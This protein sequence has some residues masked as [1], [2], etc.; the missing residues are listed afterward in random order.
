[1]SKSELEERER[2]QQAETP[3]LAPERRAADS[4]DH[5]TLRGA[6]LF[7]PE[8]RPWWKNPPSGAEPTVVGGWTF[9]RRGT[10]DVRA[11]GH[12]YFEG[13]AG[14]PVR[15]LIDEIEMLREALARARGE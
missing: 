11:V 3:L 4:A 14:P 9:E 5:G 6:E 7:A 2:R 13:R 1:M 12:W 15:A 10:S 8:R